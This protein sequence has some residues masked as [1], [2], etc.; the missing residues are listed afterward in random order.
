MKDH[1]TN[2][3]LLNRSKQPHI[4]TQIKRRK[5]TWVGRSLRRIATKPVLKFR[6]FCIVFISTYKFSTAETQRIEIHFI[7]SILCAVFYFYNNILTSS[8]F[9]ESKKAHDMY[10]Q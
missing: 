7:E 9:C 6:S 4:D 10:T 2:E 3:E 5:W 1:I 8:E